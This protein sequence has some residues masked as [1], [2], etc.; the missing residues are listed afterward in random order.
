MRHA[1][2]KITNLMSKQNKPAILNS[3]DLPAKLDYTLQQVSFGLGSTTYST[4]WETTKNKRLVLS[5]HLADPT[6]LRSNKFK[7]ANFHSGLQYT[8]IDE[9]LSSL[10]IIPDEHINIKFNLNFTFTP[11]MPF[12][13]KVMT[14]PKIE[15]AGTILVLTG[16]LALTTA[17]VALIPVVSSTLALYSITS[18]AIAITGGIIFVIGLAMSLATLFC[19]NKLEDAP[20]TIE[21]DATMEQ[22]GV[23]ESRRS[24]SEPVKKILFSRF[25]PA[26]SRTDHS[27]AESDLSNQTTCNSVLY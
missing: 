19:K 14:Y 9:E 22:V 4:L 3:N 17:L 20:K 1:Q 12:L 26:E 24:F 6:I 2:T 16:L 10:K 18:A 7:Q 15:A 5:Y 27:P 23:A 11:S 21:L 25:F 13:M 8:F